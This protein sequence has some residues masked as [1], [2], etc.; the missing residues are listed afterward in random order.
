MA[1]TDKPHC[2]AVWN[3]MSVCVC[4]EVSVLMQLLLKQK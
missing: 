3:I 1:F 2:M 4:V